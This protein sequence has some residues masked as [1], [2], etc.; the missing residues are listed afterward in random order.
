MTTS[1]NERR[2]MARN[3]YGL[4]QVYADTDRLQFAL[5]MA[6]EARDLCERL[7]MFVELAEVEELLR[8]LPG[9]DSK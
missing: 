3:E 5:E 1:W 6:Q 8:T 4:A 9:K 7:G 2:L